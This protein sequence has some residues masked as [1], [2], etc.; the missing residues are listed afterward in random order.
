MTP[1]KGEMYY[2]AHVLPKFGVYDCI[3]MKCRTVFPDMVVLTNKHCTYPVCA[4]EYDK[5]I[6]KTASECNE[7]LKEEEKLH[8]GEKVYRKEK[9]VVEEED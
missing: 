3:Y 8:K 4:N 7:F 5:F 6:Y 2:F 9:N 1:E